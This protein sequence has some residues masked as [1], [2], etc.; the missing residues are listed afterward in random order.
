[1]TTEHFD[2]EAYTDLVDYFT[3]G[4]NLKASIYHRFRV[5]REIL[6]AQG[7]LAG[8]YSL[9]AGEEVKF[10]A[11]NYDLDEMS[12]YLEDSR[13]DRLC[14]HAETYRGGGNSDIFLPQR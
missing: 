5:L 3:R 8:V 13:V 6:Q 14:I 7:L 4:E 9:H 12:I 10:M 11:T 2:L 1:M